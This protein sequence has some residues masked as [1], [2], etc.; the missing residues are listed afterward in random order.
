MRKPFRDGKVHVCKEMCSTCIF[1]P[2]NLMDL[3]PG[4]VA[5]MV[6][7]ATK[8]DS[9]ITCHSTLSGDQAVCKGFFD[10]HA[11]QPLQVAERLNMIEWVEPPSLKDKL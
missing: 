1:R 10:K 8:N 2:G 7:S 3:E 9:A 11:T 5:G 4:R 6:K